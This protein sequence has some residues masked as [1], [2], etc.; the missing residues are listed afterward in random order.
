MAKMRNGRGRMGDSREEV[1][2]AQRG[3]QLG[4]LKAMKTLNLKS[5]D[6]VEIT[7]NSR[8][9]SQGEAGAAA[10]LP[11]IQMWNNRRLSVCR[12]LQA[13]RE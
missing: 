3:S 12:H 11:P 5:G 1:R 8:R 13:R 7:S 4:R 9:R 2:Q 10:P 6:G